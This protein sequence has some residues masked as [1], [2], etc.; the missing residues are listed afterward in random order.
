VASLALW[1]VRLVLAAVVILACAFETARAQDESLVPERTL[2]AARESDEAEPRGQMSVTY[3]NQKAQGLA[4]SHATLNTGAIRAQALDFAA[5][6]RIKERWAIYGG[7]PFIARE[8]L[9]PSHNPLNIVPPQLDS[10]FVD[11]GHFHIYAQDLRLGTSYL[12][13]D[14]IIAVEPYLQYGIPASDYPFFAVAAIG[15]QLQTI[16]VGTSLAYRPPFLKWYFSARIGKE[17]A[18]K[19]LGYDIDA[20]RVTVDASYFVSPRL[21]LNVFLT[22][23]NGKGFNPP[24]TPDLTSELW[25]RHDQLTRHNFRNLGVGVDWSLGERNALNLTLLRMI[26]AEDVFKLRRAISAGLSRSF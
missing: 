24:V 5:S 13:T 16:E 20:M 17:M 1:P 15:R 7:L 4:L 11:D 3:Q 25:Y 14:E 6:Y 19:V 26:H 18:D 2:R 21:A 12:V 8:A 10:D 22:S 9:A 23:K